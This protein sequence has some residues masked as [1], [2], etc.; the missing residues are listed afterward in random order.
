MRILLYHNLCSIGAGGREA[1]EV[2][3]GIVVIH[4]VAL[5]KLGECLHRSELDG[6]LAYLCRYLLGGT[7]H[8]DAQLGELLGFISVVRALSRLDVYTHTSLAVGAYA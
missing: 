1:V 4:V 3:L 6:G 5:L 7:C 2:G 8:I